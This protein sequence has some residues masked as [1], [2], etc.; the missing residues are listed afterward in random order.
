M[1]EIAI[2]TMVGLILWLGFMALGMY[3]TVSFFKIL[4]RR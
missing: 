3:L 2:L 4:E 1:I